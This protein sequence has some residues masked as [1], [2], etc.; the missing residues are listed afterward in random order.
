MWGY[1]GWNRKDIFL[2]FCF[3]E[4]CRVVDHAQIAHIWLL[5]NFETPPMDTTEHSFK[6]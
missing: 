2:L 5:K 6:K 3:E 4:R 1:V